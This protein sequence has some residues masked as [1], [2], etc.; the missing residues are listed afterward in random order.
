MRTRNI[1]NEE[2]KRFLKEYVDDVDY[3][4][5]EEYGRIKE[6]ILHNFL[7]KNNENLTKRILWNVVPAARLKKIWEDYIRVGVV[8]D[9][10]GLNMISS[11]MIAN[12]LKL[13]ISTMLSGHSTENPDDDFE[14]AWG[15]Y[16]DDYIGRVIPQKHV[17]VD[18]TEIP[19]NNP[20]LPHIKKEKPQE[21]RPN[22][23]FDNIRNIPFDNYV[24]ELDVIPNS[25]QMRKDLMEILISYFYEYYLTDSKGIDI[26]SDYGT[27]PLVNLAFDLAKEENAEKKV[28]IID[29]MLNIVHQRSDLAA[30]FIEGGSRTLSD[31]SGY[32]VP[33]DKDSWYNSKS[34]V[35]GT[36]R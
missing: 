16:V 30:W 15:Y 5:Y 11:I 28:V 6:Q 31:I 34:A 22:P 32:Y 25:N 29:K 7:Y 4:L 18:Q 35:S 20:S 12:A 27:Q 9:I 24:N 19:F 2:I 33:A 10:K 36:N 13:S 3:D 26:M 23:N 14:E 1:I 21:Y 8:R 17:D